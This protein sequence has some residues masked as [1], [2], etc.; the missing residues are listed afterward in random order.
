MRWMAWHH[1][2]FRMKLILFGGM[3][4]ATALIVTGAA[5]LAFEVNTFRTHF[6]GQITTLADITS[7]TCAS[8]L[9]FE[10][11]EFASRVLQ[12]LEAEA[13]IERA[14]IYTAD[15]D[16]LATYRTH[17]SADL[18]PDLADLPP[19][20]FTASHLVVTR[21]VMFAGQQIG[22]IFVKAHLTEL[23]ERFQMIAV[24]LT[25]LVVASLVLSMLL[26]GYLQRALRRPIVELQETA[27]RVRR[28]GDFTVRAQQFGQ[29]EL[30]DLTAS[31][32]EMLAQIQERDD[33]ILASE[34]RYSELLGR[35]DEVVFR[36]TLPD[37]RLVFCSPGA[38]ALFGHRAENLITDPDL[39]MS[40][41]HE[42]SS[43]MFD[44]FMAQ[45][46]MGR[47]PPIIEYRV[48]DSDS[49]ECWLAQT[50]YPVHDENGNLVAIEGCF[51]D[52]SE[53]VL[54][55][56]EREKLRHELSQSHKLEALGTLTGGIAHDFNNI[57]SAIMGN[58]SLALDDLSPGDPMQ[59]FLQPILKA[60]ERASKLTR[61]ILTFSRQG[62]HELSPVDMGAI[63]DE[64]L[65][66]LRASL[67][68]TISIKTRIP[69]QIPRVLADPTQIHQVVMNLCTNAQHAMRQ[70]GGLLELEIRRVTLTES[71]LQRFPDLRPGDYLEL[72]I[73][74]SG[75]GIAGKHLERIFE[76]FFTTKPEGEGTGMGL[77]VVYGIILEH[78]GSISVQSE[79]DTGTTFRI[80]LPA[81]AVADDIAPSVEHHPNQ[82]R[83]QGHVLFVD[84]EQM[85]VDLAQRMLQR[86]G[87]KVS[88]FT[89][90]WLAVQ[91]FE[92]DPHG[93]DVVITDYTMPNLTGLELAQKM[94]ACR[95]SLPI[96]INTGNKDR[97]DKEIL[98]ELE[99]V[100]IASKPFDLQQLA[101]L[102]QDSLPKN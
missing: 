10:D 14:A 50:N 62:R 73:S 60:S 94:L 47:I 17:A 7:Q 81:L 31:F 13:S 20:Q 15:G 85:I 49:R 64:T 68:S 21:P 24:V 46:R 33:A 83:G 72:S 18:F 5:L 38:L 3:V 39:F 99:T 41:I 52:I 89:N 53:R 78:G 42:D 98:E 6:L 29:D 84:D 35:I 75:E 66:L 63:L 65:S 43:S 79:A 76:P 48:K 55:D 102:V 45:A 101:R 57:L 22:T 59:E 56:R 74:D 80:L 30:G 54:A 8:A 34:T 40:S 4:S 91:A 9:V 88:C 19:H 92:K 27:D 58:A 82:A 26:A 96:V 77:A 71:P 86:L 69:D 90:P 70:K 36:M 61:Q 51:I 100:R 16:V 67:P 95:P 97:V 12:G 93:F 2:S 32:N 28:D 37:G 11:N 87:Y 44:L 1:L 23:T 25:L